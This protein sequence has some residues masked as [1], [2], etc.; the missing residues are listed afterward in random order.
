[1]DVANKLLPFIKAK[2]LKRFQE[3]YF[4]D[5]NL[6]TKWHVMPHKGRICNAID[7]QIPQILLDEWLPSGHVS[8]K[9][10]LFCTYFCLCSTYIYIY[11][12]FK[13]LVV[14]DIK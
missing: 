7:I 5:I 12:N 10:R 4:R 14:V 3:L 2:E 8:P 1:M 13:L 6:R 11:C 9:V